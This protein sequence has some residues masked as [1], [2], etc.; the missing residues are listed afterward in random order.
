M[1]CGLGVD[2]I[3]VNRFAAWIE[4]TALLHRVFSDE[5]CDIILGRTAKDAERAAAARFAAKEAFSKAV[6]TG[7]RFH[8]RDVWV[9]HDDKGK[10]LLY[11]KNA[12]KKMLA[13]AGGN[14]LWLSLSHDAEHAVAVVMIEYQ[15]KSGEI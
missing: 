5:E 11:V 2:I 3:A 13:T 6:G 8:P 4:N 10:P 1:I 15:E 12:A 14:T 7:L 9:I